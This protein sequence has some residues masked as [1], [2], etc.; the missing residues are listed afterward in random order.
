[1]PTTT[2]WGHRYPAGAEDANG[3][4]AFQ[5]L[6]TD[7]DAVAMDDS[8]TLAARPVS[9]VGTPGKRGRYYWATDAGRLYRDNGQGWDEIGPSITPPGVITQYAG[10]V[11]PSG[12]LLCDGTPQSRSTYAALFSA[13]GTTYNIGG[14]LASEFRLPNLKGR[15]PAG[16]DPTQL[17]FNAV[18]KPGG[19]KTV[20]LTKNEMPIHNHTQTT[21]DHGGGLHSHPGGW[22]NHG[23]VT[24]GADRDHSHWNA[25]GLNNTWG[26]H[27]TN[28]GSGAQS[29]KQGYSTDGHSQSHLHGIPA[30]APGVDQNWAN[31]T[32]V[33]PVIQNEGSDGYH[34]N[35]Q[36]YITLN[37]IIKT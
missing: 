7:L 12:Y 15:V 21:H 6:A 24:D 22:H 25:G 10:A 31:I 23:G 32:S 34:E 37:Y 28:A 36:P 13:I 1:M 3:P 16:Y 4:L 27:W 19:A 26:T 18:G 5:N 29:L 9:S 17:E 11:A 35:M 33:A 8:G 2:R 30:S 20:K 14:E